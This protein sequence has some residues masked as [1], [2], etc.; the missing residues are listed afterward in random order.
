V[1]SHDRAFL[2]QV[3]TDI[4]HLEQQKLR[5]YKGDYSTF[6]K[7][8]LEVQQHLKKEHERYKAERAHLQEFVD[9][10]RY[11]AKRASLVQSR[12]K[13]IEK[14]D[15]EAPPEPVDHTAFR[16][17]IPHAPA[18]GRP[19]VQLARASFGYKKPDGAAGPELF[20]QVDLSLDGGER[21]AL[22][23]P[24]G[25]GKSTL[26]KLLL[27]Q[28]TPT[29]G[30]LSRRPGLKVA[31]FTQ[32]HA[33]QLDLQ[34]SAI[35]NLRQ[36]WPSTLEAEARSWLGQYGVQGQMQEQPCG[37]LSGGQKS[38]VAF[39]FLAY[40]KP[41]CIV[42]DEPTNHLDIETIDALI[43]A[44][45]QFEGS[46]VVVSHDQHFVESVCKELWVCGGGRIQK[47]RGEFK[48]YKK[49]VQSRQVRR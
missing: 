45:Q 44:L 19:L 28:L 15:A 33:D 26:L 11:N 2:D 8:R 32:H 10:F 22:L 20:A 3:C 16:F 21:L 39:A 17:K 47:F 24:N 46:V 6:E 30:Q 13:A 36:R 12:L 9:K 7:T 14:M 27:G 18:P 49:D 37:L 29:G 41:N 23:G 35:D 34:L 4:L 48:D 5:A 42:M 31:Q 25:A 38:R 1:V 43:L 40:E